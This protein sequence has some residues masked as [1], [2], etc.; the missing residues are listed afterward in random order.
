MAAIRTMLVEGMI[1]ASD[2]DT[3]SFPVMEYNNYFY[4]FIIII[5]FYY[6]Y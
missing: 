2:S 5:I 1:L 4:L 3:F 6:Y